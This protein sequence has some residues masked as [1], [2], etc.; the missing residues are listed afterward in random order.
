MFSIICDQ[1]KT[2]DT[3]CKAARPLKGPELDPKIPH[4]LFK[5]INKMP[6]ILTYFSALFIGFNCQR[7]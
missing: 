6:K 7:T 2:F 3:F 4:K 1:D 5:K